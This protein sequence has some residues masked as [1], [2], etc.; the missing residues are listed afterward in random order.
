MRKGQFSRAVIF[1]VVVVVLT[2][3]LVAAKAL[4][5]GI[6]QQSV[7]KSN[8]GYRVSTTM[9]KVLSMP[10]ATKD[11]AVFYKESIEGA[12]MGCIEVKE[13]FLGFNRDPGIGACFVEGE[14]GSC[15]Y[16]KLAGGESGTSVEKI[17]RESFIESLKRGKPRMTFPVSVYDRET[18]EVQNQILRVV[19]TK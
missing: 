5:T 2:L 11:R 8:M 18:G 12:E 4:S 16:F 14:S 13:V 3:F 19:V 1:I 10:C 17:S 6:K 7:A 15:R 9:E